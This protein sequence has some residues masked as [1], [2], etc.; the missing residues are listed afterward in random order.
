[1]QVGNLVTTCFSQ[2]RYD[3]KCENAGKPDIGIIV[4]M[5]AADFF[6]RT[7]IPDDCFAVVWPSDGLETYETLRTVGVVS[8]GG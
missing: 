6:K 5:S 3:Q 2:K 7:E 8:E 4:S 1:M